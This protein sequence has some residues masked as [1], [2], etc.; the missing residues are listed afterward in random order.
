[1]RIHGVMPRDTNDFIHRC[2]GESLRAA[3]KLSHQKGAKT[4]LDVKPQYKRQID[5][6]NQMP[7]DVSDTHDGGMRVCEHRQFGHLHD[8]SNFQYIDTKEPCSRIVP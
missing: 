1:M 8:F 6:R 5:Y 2:H 4:A 3:S 7:S